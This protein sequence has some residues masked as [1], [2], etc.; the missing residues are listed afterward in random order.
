MK[1]HTMEMIR[2]RVGIEAPRAEVLAKLT[3][4]EGLASWWTRD[5]TGDPDVGGELEFSFGGPDRTVVMEVVASTDRRVVWRGAA[6][7]AD[8]WVGGIFTFDVEPTGDETV[9]RFTQSWREPVEFM[10][11]CST[12]WAYYLLGLKA[13]LEGGKGTPYPGDLHISSWG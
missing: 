11:H 7:T 5:V 10:F 1:E 8:E 9:L 2:H 4:L 6:S 13:S 12:K 3:T